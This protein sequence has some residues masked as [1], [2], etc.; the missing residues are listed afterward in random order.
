V[1]GDQGRGHAVIIVPDLAA[2]ER[3]YTEVLGFR[4]SD[5]IEHGVTLRFFHCQGQSARRHTIAMVSVPR[6]VGMHHLMIEV[7]SFDDVGRAMDI[8]NER[9]IPL[10]M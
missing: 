10:F 6:I 7:R 2:A 4:V 5:T 3:F 9:H 1:T 8:S